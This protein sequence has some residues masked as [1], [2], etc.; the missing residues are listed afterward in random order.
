MHD[1]QATNEKL[2]DL[3]F[4]ATAGGISFGLLKDVQ[5]CDLCCAEY[6]SWKETLRAFDR[7]APV[8]Q[9]PEI[10]WEGY[11]SRLRRQLRASEVRP[12]PA[13]AVSWW[14]R[15]WNSSVRVPLPLAAAASVLLACA[16]VWA[17]RSRQ[18][19]A[20]GIP[21]LA[22][23]T[24]AAAPAPT[25][26]RILVTQTATVPSVPQTVVRERIVTRTVYIGGT[27]RAAE[28]RALATVPRP[29]PNTAGD[30][31]VSETATLAGFQTPGEVRLRV[32][33]SDA[34]E[35]K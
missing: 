31:P 1:C 25:P 32:I 13:P 20:F 11:Q 23:T 16:S 26:E 27:P 17:L 12:E 28:R 22:I 35:E 10:Y 19:T 6:L 15:L 5:D 14:Q 8:A 9:P 3:A 21:A 29:A 18:Q 4:D 33:K 34:Q 2:L 30:G 7:A 24:G